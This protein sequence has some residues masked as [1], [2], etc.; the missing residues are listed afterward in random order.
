[1][2]ITKQV[3]AIADAHIEAKKN[4]KFDDIHVKTKSELVEALWN[5][6]TFSDVLKQIEFRYCSVTSLI[7]SGTL[8]YTS[9]SYVSNVYKGFKN[10]LQ[11]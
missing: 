10:L 4:G 2:R 5:G 7:L 9:K 11:K 1:M 6:R 3:K 8:D